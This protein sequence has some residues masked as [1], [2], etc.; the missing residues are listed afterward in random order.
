MTET[1]KGNE[2]TDCMVGTELDT[3]N[4]LTEEQQKI[5]DARYRQLDE[6]R[7][8]FADIK[9]MTRVNLEKKYEVFSEKYPKTWISILDNDLKLGHLE[10]N[11]EAYETMFRKSKGRTYKE[12]KF[13]A[14]VQFGE[15]LANEYLY[16]TT[17][18]PTKESRNHALKNAKRQLNSETQI[19]TK[20]KKLEF[21]N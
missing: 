3:D 13:Q 12:R 14:D 5:L 21:D 18:K 10:R 4:M 19:K 2:Q 20:L 17:G 11:I 1:N 15:K 16:P 6:I 9:T 8:I 7:Q